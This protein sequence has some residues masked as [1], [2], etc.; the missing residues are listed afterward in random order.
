MF[1]VLVEVRENVSEL[2][3]VRSE[4]NDAWDFIKY[5]FY[6]AQSIELTKNEG[7]VSFI[8]IIGQNQFYVSGRI[9]VR[10]DHYQL[11]AANV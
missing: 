5:G 10:G 9:E 1:R 6:G 4:L 2:H 3:S 11:L 8:T 7:K